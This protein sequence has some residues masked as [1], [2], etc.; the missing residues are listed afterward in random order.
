MPGRTAPSPTR[1][2][3]S[4]PAER[5][6]W[7][8]SPEDARAA[9]ASAPDGLDHDEA[10]GRL[11]THGRNRLPEGKK[12]SAL[13]LFLSQLTGF[14]N[15]LLVI[16][17]GLA[18]AV[19]DTRDAAVVAA[20]VLFN[21]VLGFVQEY[22]A[23]SAVAALRS[24]LTRTA[25]VRRGGAEHM[26]PAEELVPG[27]L[28][29]LDTG[30]RVPADGRLI[31]AHSL[32]V[33]ESSLTGESTPVA[34]RVEALADAE[35]PLAERVNL[36]FN[37]T[38]VT[39]G[40][41]ELLITATGAATEMG[42][43]AGLLQQTRQGQTPLQIQISIL[44]R[45]LALIAG[46]AVAVI[47]VFE[48]LRGVP[49][50][51][52]V[53]KA[54]AIAVAAIPEGLPAVVTVTLAI[55]MRRMARV[56][57]IVKRMSAVETLGCT[58]DIC[59]DKTG[60][61]TLNQMTAREIVL[62][63]RT[64]SVTGEGYRPEGRIEDTN[65]DPRGPAALDVL[66]RAA[67]LCND[68]TV[69]KGVVAGDPTEGA[70]WVL[71]QKGGVD[72]AALRQ[73]EPRVAEV[74]FEA[75]RK[76]SAT[77]HPDGTLFAK[78]APDVL[79][80]RCTQTLGADGAEPLDDA[81]RARA[82]AANEDMAR[83][84]LRVLALAT[85]RVDSSSLPQGTDGLAGE[86]S[87]LTLVALVGLLDPPRVEA[88]EAIALCRDAGISIRMIT[89]DHPSTG[90]AIARALGIEGE[91]ISGPELDRMDQ[92]ELARR[93]PGLGVL[94]RVSPEHK[95]RAVDA[96]RARGRVVAM[97]G[98]GVNDAPA[99]K[100]ADIGVAMGITGTDVTKEA[101]TLVLADD[102][103]A[104]IVGAVKEGRTIYDNIVR[105]LRFQLSTNMGA[106]LAVFAA[107]FLGLPM[108]FTPLQI[109]W[110]NVIMDGPPAMTLGVD[111]PHPAIM[112]RPPR[113]P[114][115]R[116]LTGRRLAV[117]LFLGAIMAAGTLCTLAHALRTRP[118]AA[119]ITLAFTTFVLFQVFN[120]FNARFE[121]DSA[122]GRHTFTNWR[123][124]G[125]LATIIGLQVAVVHVPA[126]QS[127]LDTT[128]LSMADW[129]LAAAVAASVLVLEE[130]RKLVRRRW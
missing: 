105:F 90:L 84:G 54:V 85:R 29:L 34:K 121:R 60:T 45:R 47:V 59:S 39:R 17:A 104:T 27:D 43:L 88:R 18:L 52:L 70:L 37:N 118:A 123:L 94:A 40:R 28:V 114:G 102:N 53:V 21:A 81:G 110:V 87:D 68:S 122:L 112:R 48:L 15:L 58:T 116:I 49:L 130:L 3:T 5:P 106:L 24:M 44:G 108:P 115:S 26:I 19:G 69:N 50:V 89:G 74:P 75:D 9:L 23:E 38:V 126:L 129:G 79:L 71:A 51:N 107:P 7:T 111:P 46:V 35:L 109:L 61:L 22:R 42:R 98:D 117:L 13:G 86:V 8:I 10:R 25:R 92:D 120:V 119:A 83:R 72:V 6:I 30:D 12:R 124:W 113:E 73:A 1:D 67:A 127:V 31:A 99:L 16:A 101:A 78:G 41:G 125:A 63:G 77:V 62:E 65:E 100:R 128:A 4:P 91:A 76:F 14:L 33:D 96:L 36:G 97:I 80:P 56:R 64:L 11:A 66:L 2:A 93:M 95:L 57:A 82:L 55:G 32:E 20:V 103:F